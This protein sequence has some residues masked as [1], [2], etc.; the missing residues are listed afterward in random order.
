MMK[1]QYIIP[2]TVPVRL[3]LSDS[4]LDEQFGGSETKDYTGEFANRGGLIDDEE[5]ADGAGEELSAGFNNVWS[6]IGE[7]V[8]D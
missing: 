6:S 4:V 8:E 2:E 1:K 7:T 5:E 3:R